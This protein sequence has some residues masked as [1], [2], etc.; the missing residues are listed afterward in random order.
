M[1]WSLFIPELYFLGASVFFLCM[2]MGKRWAGAPYGRIAQVLAL[3][4]VGVC[5]MASRENGLLFFGAYRI[6][7]FS[8]VFKVFLCIG[9][10]LAVFLCTDLSDVDRRYHP[11]FFSLLF[12]CTLAVMMLVSAV[13]LLAVYVALEL[14][15]YSLYVLVALRKDRHLG[16][17]AGI[18]Y[19]L[20]GVSASAVMLFGMAILYGATHAV[21]LDALTRSLPDLMGNPAVFAGVVLTLAGFF[22]KL[23]V[24]PFHFWVPDVYKAAPTPLAAYIATVS[25]VAAIA[26]L[27]RVMAATGTPSPR[28]VDLLAVLS[29]ASMTAGN[30]AAL[31]QKDLKRL[32]GYSS[33]AHAGY[34]L[35]GILTAT[36]AGYAGA[37]FYA[38]AILV[39]TFSAFFVVSKV[40]QSS[41]QTSMEALAGLHRRSPLLALLLMVSMFSLAGIPPTFGFTA[42]FVVFA[43]AMAR[44]HF[45][46]VLIAMINVV[47]SLYYYLQVLKAAYLQEAPAAEPPEAITLSP[48]AGVLSGA[49]ILLMIVAGI[50]PYELVELTRVI[51][52]GVTG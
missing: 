22:F 50:C 33:I 5:L 7:F 44:N 24:F 18:K 28:M 8:Q 12:I 38:V 32:L 29:I 35:I 14:S 21:T 3:L 27:V 30:L 6:D 17:S 34:A 42:K 41:G 47:I 36:S 13:H 48:A 23:A 46:L 45:A 10:F 15:S 31:V 26:V 37:A 4:G 1:T 39:M 19:F 9:L 51:V 25:K 40:E 11:E 52:Q 20:T 16:V 43:A 2:S 49:L